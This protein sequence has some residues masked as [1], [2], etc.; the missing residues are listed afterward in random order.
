MP[1]GVYFFR[2]EPTVT[3][4]LFWFSVDGDNWIQVGSLTKTTAFTTGPDEW[5][6]YADCE[7]NTFD[8]GIT[9]ISWNES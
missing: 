9:L 8:V 3:T 6:F 4:M 2:M 1:V 5:G 7:S